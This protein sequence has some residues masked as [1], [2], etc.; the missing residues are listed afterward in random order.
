L[1]KTPERT[2]MS[3]LERTPET[4]NKAKLADH[5]FDGTTNDTGEEAPG[6]KTVNDGYKEGLDVAFGPEA[7][8]VFEAQGG[9]NH[10]TPPQIVEDITVVL[11]LGLVPA[12]ILSKSK[13]VVDVKQGILF[14]QIG[15]PLPDGALWPRTTEGF[16]EYWEAIYVAREHGRLVDTAILSSGHTPFIEKSFDVHGLPQPDMMITEEVI[17]EFLFNSIPPEYR[18]K[19]AP[20]PLSISKIA[21]AAKYGKAIH[22]KGLSESMNSKILLVGDS[23]RADG[24]LATNVGVHFELLDP[25]APVET[26]QKATEWALGSR[27][28][29]KTYA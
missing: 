3:S 23:S 21:W 9:H 15:A 27:A 11:R 5:D 22:E 28:V 17:N 24:G 13:Q 6:I 14:D 18:G 12:D 29:Q 4:F 25:A 1:A 16:R 7:A 10:R 26:W 20:L 8:D 19:P 2:S